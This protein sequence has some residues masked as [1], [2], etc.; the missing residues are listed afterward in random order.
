MVALKITTSVFTLRLKGLTYTTLLINGPVDVDIFKIN[1]FDEF[2]V[3]RKMYDG[4]KK[5]KRRNKTVSMFKR[6]PKIIIRKKLFPNIII[7]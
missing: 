6:R 4:S 5:T 3:F 2:S 1:I 7:W